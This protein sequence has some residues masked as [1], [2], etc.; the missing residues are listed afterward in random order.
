MF[1]LFS[2]SSNA[3]AQTQEENLT[4]TILNLDSAFWK[5]YNSCDTAGNKAFFT[6][7][8]EFYHDKGGITLGA[9]ALI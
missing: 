6:D 1:I 9:P 2:C 4:A 3:I 7:D 8:V 5:T